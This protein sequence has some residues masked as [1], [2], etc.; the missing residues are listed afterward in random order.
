MTCSFSR[1][2][3]TFP[4]VSS[5]PHSKK[6]GMPLLACQAPQLAALGCK[7]PIISTRRN[8]G[9][10]PRAVLGQRFRAK[11]IIHDHSTGVVIPALEFWSGG[12]WA[13]RGTH[14]QW[15]GQRAISTRSAVR[16]LKILKRNRQP[17]GAPSGPTGDF[18]S[19]S[20]RL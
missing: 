13:V 14:Y 3:V 18:W 1:R 15:V 19:H 4:T 17:S 7:K 5:F 6:C 2:T 12:Q 11:V 8:L 9:E 20:P 16:N 10:G